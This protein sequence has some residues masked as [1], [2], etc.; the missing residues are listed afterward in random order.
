MK[1]KGIIVA[2]FFGVIMTTSLA[3]G[4]FVNQVQPTSPD[5]DLTLTGTPED[6]FPDAQRPQFC[7]SGDAK[8][9]T[10]VTEYTIPTVCTNPLAIVTDYDGNVW[11]AQTNTGK[12][13]KFNPLTESFTEYENPAWPQGGR[14]MMW[15]IDAAP[16]GSIWYTDETFDSVWKFSPQEEKYQRFTYP[17]DGDS[18]PQK[19]KVVGSQIIINDFT[20]NKITFLDPTQ[21]E[22]DFNYLSLPSP[23][24]DSVTG[25]FAI[26]AENNIW[27]TNW[28]FQQ[29]GVLVKFDQE[30]YRNSVATSGEEVLPLFDY[31]EIIQLPGNLITPNGAVAT[32][33]G[34]IWLVDTSSSHFFSFN[35]ENEEFIQYVTSDPP[36]STYGNSTG[37]I[38]TPISRPYWIETNNLGQ[39]VFNEQT[40]NRL[41][42]MDPKSESLVEYFVPSMNPNWGDCGEMDNCGL[43]QIFDFTVDGDKI[44]FTEWVENN[45]GVVDTSI[46][47]PLDIE[48]DSNIIYLKA[49]QSM[50]LNFVVSPKTS[51]DFSEVSLIFSEPNQF[52]NV[53]VDSTVPQTFQLDFDAP[54][55]ILATIS[56]SDDAI[57]GTYKALIGAQTDEVSVS[58]FVTIIIES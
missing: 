32:E 21:T 26:D 36:L 30:G 25:D 37:I 52:L 6:N 34:K 33:D 51:Q 41:A 2:I 18:L 46:G 16:D 54:R 35:P 48:L 7:G 38:K 58:K 45:I 15:G 57:P 43:A 20:G 24:D 49:G 42:V 31:L 12:L 44:W 8:T 40:A 10:Y 13:A 50:D 1:K 14:S 3:A 39:L 11:F 4:A 5:D 56:A 23:V 55:P 28:L 17:S 29:S 27:Y 22:G 19:L 53:A 9:T 47:L